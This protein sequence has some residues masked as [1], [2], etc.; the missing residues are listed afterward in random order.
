MFRLAGG[1]S[2]VTARG[3]TARG[4]SMKA[5]WLMSAAVAAVPQSPA[6]WIGADDYPPSAIESDREGT[7]TITLDVDEQGRP[8]AC[9]VVAPS[10]Y[11][12]LDALT[13]SLLMERASFSPARDD[14][15]RAVKSMYTQRVA[16]QIPR[17]R[18][19]TQGAKVTFAAEPDGALSDCRIEKYQFQDDDLQCD[20][21]MVG[22]LAGAFLPEALGSY[23]EVSLTLAMDV[24][25]SDIVV[26]R[27]S[28]EDR[29]VLA[30]AIVEV[31]AS[32]VVVACRTDVAVDLGEGPLDLCAGPVE[33]GA[34]D[35][36]PDPEGK[37]RKIAVSF[38]VSGQKR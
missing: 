20:S 2:R 32:G 36:A 14:A 22:A 15:G 24:E 11:A 31:S 29:T 33:T 7:T 1:L 5:L 28:G 12:E 27:R 35:F 17:E 10:G 26:P 25:G 13:C 30:R 8:S 34:R 16:W 3:G 23:S 6:T 9:R 4:E 21:Q 18:L 19:V 38:E 37:V